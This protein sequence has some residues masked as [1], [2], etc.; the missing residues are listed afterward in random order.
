MAVCLWC[1][2]NVPLLKYMEMVQFESLFPGSVLEKMKFSELVSD[3]NLYTVPK[4]HD[5]VQ[6]FNTWS[7]YDP[8][9]GNW[10]G[11]GEAVPVVRNK[12]LYSSKLLH[13]K[14]TNTETV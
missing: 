12:Q 5:N 10:G 2:W 1:Q 4:L 14:S 3:S 7:V 11:G 8:G 13:V 9:W 6:K